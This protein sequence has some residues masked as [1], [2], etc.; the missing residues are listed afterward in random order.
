MPSPEFVNIENVVLA[1]WANAIVSENMLA[2]ALKEVP[3]C[4]SID[5]KTLLRTLIFYIENDLYVLGFPICRKIF[6][7]IEAEWGKLPDN[8]K[9]SVKVLISALIDADIRFSKLAESAMG[10]KH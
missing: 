1:R 2:L 10:R 4:L 9:K 6:L 8:D 5:L 7:R 3:P